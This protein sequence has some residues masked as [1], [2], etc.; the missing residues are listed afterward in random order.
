MGGAGAQ[1]GAADGEA[2]AQHLAERDLCA[3]ARQQADEHDA[4]AWG[5][6]PR[7]EGDVVAADEV[8]HDV[9]CAHRRDRVDDVAVGRVRHDDAVGEPERRRRGDL[10][11]RAGRPDRTGAEGTAQLHRGG[12]DA[13]PDGVDEHGVARP[14]AGLSDERVVGRGEHLD[15]GAGGD[16]VEL[17]GH[18]HELVVLDHQLLGV[19]AAAHEAHDAV[20]R[21]PP[22]GVR[23]ERRDPARELEAGHVVGGARGCRVVARHLEEVGA[24]H[25][26]RGD[27]DEHLAAAGGG[28][29]SLRDRQPALLDRR[30][31]HGVLPSSWS[32]PVR[33]Q[34]GAAPPVASHARRSG[35]TAGTAARQW[36]DASNTSE[37]ASMPEGTV[38]WFSNEKGF[39]FIAPD[40]GGDDLFVH[41]SAITG[42]GYKSLEEN[43][44]VSFV[45]TE[46]RKGPQADQVTAL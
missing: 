46:G 35:P 44:R 26:G 8:E 7:V 12:A 3:G 41:Y 37:A 13:R 10:L 30:C 16:V 21:R 33:G 43:Q 39:G 5:G 36:A 34:H 2:L 11:G 1:D 29:R 31:A 25:P 9:R 19:P 17:V 24:V 45:V 6:D 14:Q 15:A 23:S 22:P 20:A 18:G 27:V 32:W 4:G 42:S 40:E 28:G 38:R